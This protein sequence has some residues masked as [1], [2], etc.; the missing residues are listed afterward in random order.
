MAGARKAVR[1]SASSLRSI[2]KVYFPTHSADTPSLHFF[3]QTSPSSPGGRGGGW[4]KRAG[5]MRPNGAACGDLPPSGLPPV[6]RSEG[7]RSEENGSSTTRKP[8]LSSRKSGPLP[9]RTA[10]R[11]SLES[12]KHEPPRN[13]RSI[14]GDA[15][16]LSRPSSRL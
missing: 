16:T 8:M 4:E 14:C 6:Q 11:T 15:S 10:Q 2:P 9:L 1:V 7:Q 13:T 5:V 12:E 3:G